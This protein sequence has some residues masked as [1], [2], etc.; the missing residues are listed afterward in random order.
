[1]HITITYGADDGFEDAALALARRVFAHYDEA[2]E[3]LVLV[4]VDDEDLALHLDG[5]LVHSA[6]QSGRLP[7]VADL[8]AAL[9]AR[10]SSSMS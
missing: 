9:L 4:P 3:S 1:M 2:V 6:N 7:L 10:E 5:A 8:R